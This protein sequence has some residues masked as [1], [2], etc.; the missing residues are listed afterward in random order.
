MHP[1]LTTRQSFNNFGLNTNGN[2]RYGYNAGNGKGGR[3]YD[4]EKRNSFTPGSYTSLDSNYQSHPPL[5]PP[6]QMDPASYNAAAAAAAYAYASVV[7]P[8][9][10]TAP[11]DTSAGGTGQSGVAAVP[12]ASPPAVAGA[13]TGDPQ[14]YQGTTYYPV[15]PF[16]FANGMLYPTG[17]PSLSG[18][19]GAAAGSNPQQ[20]FYYIP[21]PA[22]AMYASPYAQYSNPNAPGAA[23]PPLPT[24]GGTPGSETYPGAA[25]GTPA[26]S[27]SSTDPSSTPVS[28]PMPPGYFSPQHPHMMP[29]P[30]AATAPGATFPPPQPLPGPNG[31]YPAASAYG[32]VG[33]AG[34]FSPGPTDRGGGR[35]HNGGHAQF[36]GGGTP[37]QG[38]YGG[39]PQSP[40]QGGAA[41]GRPPYYYPSPGGASMGASAPGTPV[42]GGVAPVV[43]NGSGQPSIMFSPAGVVTG[44][45]VTP[46]SQS[47]FNMPRNG[48]SS[49]F[50]TPHQHNPTMGM[51]AAGFQGMAGANGTA[52][53][54][55]VGPGHMHTGRRESAGS[56][57]SIASSVASS[58]VLNGSTVA[59]SAPPGSIGGQESVLSSPTSNTNLYIRGLGNAATDEGLYEM[60]KGYGRIYSSK[61]I[62]DLVT[63]E[64]KGYGFVMYESDEEAKTAMDGLIKLGYQVSFAKTDPRTPSAQESFNAKLKNLH[65]EESTNIYISNLPLDM[66]E[67]GM[68]QLFSPH[69]VISNKILRDPATQVSRGVGF[70]RMEARD[71]AVSVIEALNGTQLPGAVQPLQVRFAD[72]VAQK[73]LKTQQQQHHMQMGHPLSPLQHPQTGMPMLS[74]QHLMV[75]QQHQPSARRRLFRSGPNMMVCV[76]SSPVQGVAGVPPPVMGTMSTTPS[77]DGSGAGSVTGEE[78]GL[79]EGSQGEGEGASAGYPAYYDASGMPQG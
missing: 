8:Y 5:A 32:R 30:G 35:R 48:T 24:A 27:G 56:T 3:R 70:A 23:S 67:E 78:E 15:P 45:A 9:S 62:I 38:I 76:G 69:K 16:Y 25:S 1:K 11:Q 37:Q 54:P 22:A 60:C 72:S 47:P 12:G 13:G 68:L 63:H 58:A 7:T 49:A 36:A 19:A 50:H 61:A 17:V 26:A 31:G 64:C 52:G 43:G 28:S 21:H 4:R 75:P 10:S 14:S 33:P 44:G 57:Q 34:V 41:G 18:A 79:E 66:D 65:D 42:P 40:F 46:Q 20:K 55:N 71:A 39:V 51:G 53:G 59:G 6:H 29:Y 73:K 77:L 2:G 74:P